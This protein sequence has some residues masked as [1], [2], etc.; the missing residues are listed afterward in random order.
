VT[1]SD[2]TRFADPGANSPSNAALGFSSFGAL[3]TTRRRI[4]AIACSTGHAAKS[5][6]VDTPKAVTWGPL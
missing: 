2:F 5:R 4:T 6:T 1:F 3:V